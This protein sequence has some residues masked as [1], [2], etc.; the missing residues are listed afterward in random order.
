MLTIQIFVSTQ[1]YLNSSRNQLG[2]VPSASASHTFLASLICK[3][4]ILFP[5]D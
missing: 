2:I 5:G 4:E 1:K 3:P